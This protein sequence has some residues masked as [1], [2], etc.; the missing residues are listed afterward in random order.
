[1]KLR[2]MGLGMGLCKILDTNFGEY[3]FHALR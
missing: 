3:L 1:L 2:K